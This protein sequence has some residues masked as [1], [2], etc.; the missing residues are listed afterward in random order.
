M[1]TSRSLLAPREC[2]TPSVVLRTKPQ[3]EGSNT[4]GPIRESATGWISL[5]NLPDYRVWCLFGWPNRLQTFN[6]LRPLTNVHSKTIPLTGRHADSHALPRPPLRIQAMHTGLCMSV[7]HSTNR[8]I[9]LLS[10]FPFPFHFLETQPNES[11]VVADEQLDASSSIIYATQAELIETRGWALIG[12]S[13]F[14][15]PCSLKR[16]SV[17]VIQ[18]PPGATVLIPST[19]ICYS[20]VAI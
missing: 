11:L 17:L 13:R 10:Y 4:L 2:Y 16:N 7:C 12:I 1:P 6:S 15:S 8:I 20:N 19:R 3:A 14:F 5:T 9:L 18:S